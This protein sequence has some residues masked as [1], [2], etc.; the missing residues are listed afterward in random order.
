VT[1]LNGT[2]INLTA[3][4]SIT[5]NQPIDSSLNGLAG[6]L[7]LTAPT[8]NLNAPI[9]LRT[10]SNLLGNAS[11]VNVGVNGTVQNGV[12]V[13]ASGAN[14]NLAAAT[15][16]LSSVVNI[17]KN[18]TLNGTGAANTTVSGNNAVQVLN[19]G[20]NSTVN[21]NNLTVTN[22]KGG[23]GGGGVFI[24]SES[25]LSINNSTFSNNTALQEGGAIFNR[26][27]IS[28]IANSTFSTNS[29]NL[30]GG[31]IMNQGTISAITNS[32]F[33]GNSAANGGAIF[34]TLSA[35]LAISNSTFSGNS[36]ASGGAIYSIGTVTIANSTFSGNSATGA[37][38]FNGNG[39]AIYNFSTATISNSTFSGNLATNGGGGIYVEPGSTLNINNSTFSGNSAASGGAIY[40]YGS[41]FTISNSTFSGN[42][43]TNGGGI[44]VEPDSGSGSG[45]TLNINNS[46]FSGNLA[47]N[48]GGAIYNND[49]ATIAN[50][51]IIGNTAPLGKEISTNF[52]LNFIGTNIVGTNGVNGIDGVFTTATPIIVPT[53]AAN[54]VIN[55]TLAY[56]GGSTQTFALLAGSI[57]INA[58]S[59]DGGATPTTTDQRGALAVGIRDI[60]AFEFSATPPPTPTPPTNPNQ[61][62]LQN[63]APS[64]PPSTT[65]YP[66]YQLPPNS[67][68]PSKTGNLSFTPSDL[69]NFW[70]TP[71]KLA[72]RLSNLALNPKDYSL[73]LPSNPLIYIPSSSKDPLF[74]LVKNIVAVSPRSLIDQ[75]IK[76]GNLAIA[77][78]SL[79]SRNVLALEEYTGL[80]L[81]TIRSSTNDIIE[82][83]T[84]QLRK[85]TK[86]TGSS[87]ASI[88]PVI[89]DNR[90]ELLVVFP[91]GKII[92]KSV[93]N[94]SKEEL[95]LV[96]TDFRANLLDSSSED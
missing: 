42:L 64:L 29:V 55:T 56:N 62:T 84:Q 19:I 21:I 1:A 86:V 90:L 88:Y 93:T 57:A 27:T 26:G 73:Y 66:A 32:T 39:G 72:D 50:S 65:V 34:G 77:I 38:K 76:S 83:I 81:S 43:A 80:K 44:Y 14:V 11:T 54:T 12:D 22:G 82:N 41:T 24:N 68:E 5:V 67:G 3:T 45:S 95:L 10:G 79:E 87:T 96:I 15:Y 71:S 78:A 46:T 8:A 94:I 9:T 60:G 6:N 74:A 7:T 91:N 4:N 17:N 52:N 59:N 16:T 30:N 13:A 63:G 89:L 37:T 92:Q 58:S 69:I 70:S 18:L 2:D 49:T 23:I 61:T 28:A 75:F 51:I 85:A 47:T 20:N 35:I 33:S 40:N 53:G 48:G 25:I 31:A 36:A